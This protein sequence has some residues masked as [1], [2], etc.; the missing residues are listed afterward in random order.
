VLLTGLD[1]TGK[2]RETGSDSY[3]NA[4]ATVLWWA[5]ACMSNHKKLTFGLIWKT[6]NNP[7]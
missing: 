3:Y 1:W 4:P 2:E 7:D 5:V 6:S